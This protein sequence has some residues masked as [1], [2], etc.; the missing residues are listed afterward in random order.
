MTQMTQAFHGRRHKKNN[1][2]INARIKNGKTK[3]IHYI[4]REGISR[5]KGVIKINLKSFSH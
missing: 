2:F 4:K 1:T 3:K 5:N